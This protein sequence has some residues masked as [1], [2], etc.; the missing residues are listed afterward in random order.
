M[1]MELMDESA[2]ATSSVGL[3]SRGSP[4]RDPVSER[5]EG[6]KKYPPPSRPSPD[7]SLDVRDNGDAVT[8]DDGRYV[9]FSLVKLEFYMAQTGHVDVP[10]IRLL[11]L[12]PEAQVIDYG[13]PTERGVTPTPEQKEIP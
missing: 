11:E 2:V 4:E 13:S 3:P 5:F 7:L 12:I 1:D 10:L 6:G 8:E 9:R